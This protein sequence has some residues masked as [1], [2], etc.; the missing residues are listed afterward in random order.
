MN[1]VSVEDRATTDGEE[2]AGVFLADQ[3]DAFHAG[4]VAWVRLDD[5]RTRLAG[6]LRGP[7]CT[8]S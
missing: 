5:R 7:F 4:F 6:G 2:K 8:W 1:L 3:I